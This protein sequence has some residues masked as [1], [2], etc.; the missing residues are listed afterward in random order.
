MKSYSKQLIGTHLH[1]AQNVGYNDHFAPGSGLIDFEM[2]K[3]YL[4]DHAIR[5]IEVHP[6][7]AADELKR[8][9]QFLKE[10]RIIS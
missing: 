1:D 7:V 5:I 8:G 3:R 2:V 4:P 6:K 10:K 9:V